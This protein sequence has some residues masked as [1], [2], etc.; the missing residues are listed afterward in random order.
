MTFLVGELASEIR[1]EGQAQYTRDLDRMGQLTGRLGADTSRTTQAMRSGFTAAAGTITAAAAAGTVLG[2]SLFKTGAA[3][4]TLQQTSRA[5]LNTLLGGAEQ[6][7]AQM[8]KL[9]EFARTS[10]FAKGVFI[11]AQQQLIGFGMSAE[12]VI[13]TLDAIQNAVAATGGSSQTLS[14]ITYVLAQIQAAGKIT[15]TDLMQL[16]QRGVDAATIIGSQMGKTGAQIRE[17][18][19]AGALSADDAL[20][21]LTTGLASKFEGA[22]ANVKGTWSGTVD[23]IKAGTREIGAAMAEPFIGQNGGGLAVEWGNQVAD[24]LQGIRGHAKPVVSVFMSELQPA[25]AG[26]TRTLDRANTVVRSWDSSR[27][28]SFL[29]TSKDYAPGVA[30]LGGAVVALSSGALRGIPVIGGLVPVLNPVVTALV[31][32]AAASPEVRAGALEVLQA[33]KPLIPVAGDLAG[34]IA[35]GLNI[36]APIAAD[37][38]QL[39]AAVARPLVDIVAGIPAPVLGA[40]AGFLALRAVAGPLV[41]ALKGAYT[42]LQ[43]IAQQVAVQSALAGMAGNTNALAGAMGVASIKATTLGNSIKAAFVS[44]PIGLILLGASTAVALLTAAFTAQAEQAKAANDRIASYRRTLADTTGQITEA[45]RAQIEQNIANSDMADKLKLLGIERQTYV[46]AI[47][48]EADAREKVAAAVDKVNGDREVAYYGDLK[49]AARGV[50]ED[51]ENQS[52]ALVQAAQDTRDDARAKREQAAAAGEAARSNQRLNDALAIARDVTRDATERLNALKQALDELNG[53]TKTQAQATRDLYEQSDRLRDV[54]SA[55]D[56]AGAKLAPTL[57]NAAGAIDTTTAAGR[58][59]FDETTRLNDQMLDAI[60]NEDKLAKARGEAGVSTERAAA[61]AQPYIDQL[62][63]IATESGLGAEQVDGLVQTMLSAPGVIAYLVT[64]NG[65]IDQEKQK[66]LTLAQEVLNTPDGTFQVSS[67]SFPG[68][69]AALQALGVK[70]TTLPNGTVKVVKNDGSFVVVENSLNNLVR[71]RTAQIS[72]AFSATMGWNKGAP[73]GTGTVLKPSSANGNLF[74]RGRVQAFANG[75]FP[76]GIFRGGAPMYKFAEPETGWEA[77]ISGRK[78]QEARNLAIAS[79]AVQ[80]LGGRVITPEQLRSAGSMPSAAGTAAAIPAG[81]SGNV[82]AAVIDELRALRASLGRPN[83][84]LINPVT[85]DWVS[86]LR[87]LR[88]DEGT[89]GIG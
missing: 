69:M 49:T 54:F 44:N 88:D 15:A 22:A 43:S 56:D 35:S 60:L 58:A 17:D 36:A 26:V 73:A 78:G 87:S 74:D 42:G 86:D 76:T 2:V 38:L 61:V 59:L 68:L 34:V 33:F 31:A 80:R 9:D 13:P 3:Y 10:P 71:S 89:E 27:L 23:R 19:T 48:G 39:I 70:T 51:L 7:N 28:E 53:G 75:G 21:A 50:A 62:R 57:V 55:T 4:N 20:A 25:V 67:Q 40:V 64:D 82:L 72:A 52:G 12:K 6:A 65:T 63:A 85:R 79:D 66:L 83:V 16:G 29:R 30:A 1:L 77:F 45:T 46:Q 41:P 5:A 18:I 8:D 47:L 32:A 14:E 24:V 11:S 84:S 37:G 81:D